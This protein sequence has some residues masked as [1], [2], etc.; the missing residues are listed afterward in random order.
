M[1]DVIVSDQEG[2]AGFD[3]SKIDEVI[4]SHKYT[5][6]TVLKGA[7]AAGA[8]AAVGPVLSACGSSS[9]SSSSSPS[10]AAGPKK[11]GHIRSGIGGG[12][13]KD[14]LDAHLPTS[15]VQI[16]TQWQIYDA[17]LG[18]DETHKL[19]NLL[20]E[21]YTPNADGTKFQVK[22]K[23]GLEFH[24]GKP[25]TADD[26]VYSFQR[27]L[28]PKTTAVGASDL[29]GLKATGVKKVDNL[30]V[31]FELSSPNVIFYEALADYRNAIVP[32]GYNPKGMTG[33]IGTGPWKVTGFQP[34]QQT[35]FAANQNYWGTGPYAD[36]LTMIE[37]AD[38]TA[39]LNALQ[40]GTVDHI[41][42]LASAQASVV[43]GNPAMQLLQSKSGAWEPFTMRMDQKPFNDPR[44]R[45]A[46]RLIVDRQ[47][48]I[49]QAKGGYAWVAND[50]YSPYDPGYPKDVPQR[51]QDIAQAKSLLKAAG[52]GNGLTVQLTTS[53]A[54][55]AGDVAAAQ[56]FA[57]QAKAA[58]VTVQINNV[59]PSVFYGND[60]L[61]WTFAQD[62]WATRNY[63]P[64]VQNGSATTAPWN[65]C[66]WK[67]AE[68][69]ALI[70]QAFKTI[71]DTKRNELVS[72]AEKIEYERGA[73]II[74]AFD[75]SMDAHTKKLQ[76]VVADNWGANSACRC[77]YNL[78]YFA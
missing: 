9:G 16:G 77:R 33:A 21:S 59:D 28:N 15:E 51:V 14:T 17:L 58:G 78:M 13:A 67:D 62:F 39:K 70:N 42:L 29:V 36:Q 64:Q 37:F 7:A 65:E 46:F 19:V 45:Q 66:H 6:R 48:M 47:Q 40:G 53:T 74:W 8:L 10:A 12:S 34:G 69:Q 72:Q 32:V 24:N 35:E 38:P 25:V 50:M 11:G 23:S 75:I 44:V 4:N 41:T 61:K 30:T 71:D 63:L 68:W 60:Y 26:V 31:S 20:A 1:G 52:Y 43:Q 18:W 5:R 27:I 76:G 22:L 49:N 57:Q 2:K 3:L 54:V 56:V 55:G 73:Y